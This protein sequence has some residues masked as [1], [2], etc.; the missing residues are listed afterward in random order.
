MDSHVEKPQHYEV[1][2]ESG[3]SVIGFIINKLVY[4]KD[5]YLKFLCL[6]IRDSNLSQKI[7]NVRPLSYLPDP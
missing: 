3:P 6:F 1:E 5:L 4:V 7:G 2:G